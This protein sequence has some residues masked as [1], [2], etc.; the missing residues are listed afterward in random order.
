MG[1]GREP[2]PRYCLMARGLLPSLS[3]RLLAYVVPY[4][5]RPAVAVQV[6]LGHKRRAAAYLV[7]TTR[8]SH[9]RVRAR[10]RAAD[11]SEPATC[12][13]HQHPQ[14]WLGQDTGIEAPPS[15]GR[16]GDSESP[17]VGDA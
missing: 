10:R 11:V 9:V 14:P 8:A 12:P 15:A 5:G 17:A 2:P 6:I 16:R 3:S 7:Q 4:V 1:R 13:G